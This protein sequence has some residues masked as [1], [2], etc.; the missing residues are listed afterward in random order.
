MI[1][2]PIWKSKDKYIS[3]LASPRRRRTYSVRKIRRG[4][5]TSV[6]SNSISHRNVSHHYDYA[7]V[8]GDMV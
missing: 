4:M 6:F 7:T 8:A 2:D 5:I 3:I 1:K